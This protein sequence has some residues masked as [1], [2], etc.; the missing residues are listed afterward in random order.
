LTVIAS[1][2]R[3]S[4]AKLLPFSELL[5]AKTVTKTVTKTTDDGEEEIARQIE[6]FIKSMMIKRK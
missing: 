6:G 5:V 3:S 4:T 1:Q 2:S